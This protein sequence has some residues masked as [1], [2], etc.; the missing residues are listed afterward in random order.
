MSLAPVQIPPALTP[1]VILARP[2]MGENIGATARAMKNCG[3]FS[4]RLVSPR[5]GWPNPAA[6]PMASNAAD[7]LE[8]AGVYNSL[9]DA[10]HDIG[11]LVATSARPRNMEKPVFTPRDAIAELVK[12]Q[13]PQHQ[14]ENWRSAMLFGAER[15]GLD[16][17]ELMLADC[18][19]QA[20]LNPESMSLNLAQAVLLM[21]W[22]W[23]MAAL[24]E[25]GHLDIETEGVSAPADLKKRAYF[26]SRLNDF[27][28]REEFFA[29][30][31]MAPITQR[32]LTCLLARSAPTEQELNTLHGILTLFE[33]NTIAGVDKS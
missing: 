21:A 14:G 19:A 6:E 27:L 7:I 18:V 30:A 16:N 32:N 15:S 33:R 28:E 31:E 10:L 20:P 3:L 8:T 5:D 29:N 2:Q 12:R 24:A 11:Y 25:S 26:M 23:R 22:E 13:N 4:L 17:E 9:P 1:V